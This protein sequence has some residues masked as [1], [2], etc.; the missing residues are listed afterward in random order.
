MG[1]NGHV[2]RAGDVLKTR[3]YYRA[4]MRAPLLKPIVTTLVVL[5]LGSI[6]FCRMAQVFGFTHHLKARDVWG[7]IES[8]KML[9][10][11]QGGSGANRVDH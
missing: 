11:L 10:P 6:P 9:P 1:E 8:P 7:S 3:P 5:L 2:R 4:A